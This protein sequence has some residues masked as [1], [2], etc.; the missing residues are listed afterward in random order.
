MLFDSREIVTL[1]WVNLLLEKCTS[2]CESFW[3]RHALHEVNI[4]VSCSVNLWVKIFQNGEKIVYDLNL[5]TRGSELWKLLKCQHEIKKK[6]LL[7][8]VSTIQLVVAV[9]S[10]WKSQES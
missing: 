3:Q 5:I 10:S 7:S 2:I 8:Q 6:I 1:I 9:E 4:I